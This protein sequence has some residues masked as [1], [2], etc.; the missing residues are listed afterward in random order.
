M[1]FTMSLAALRDL[2]D[3]TRL[4]I[5][6]TDRDLT[7]ADESR[8]GERLAS[9]LNAWTAHRQ[10][11]TAGFDVRHGRFLLVGLDESRVAASGCS[12]DALLRELRGL[13]AELGLRLTDAAPVW[14]RT[15][16]GNVACVPRAG[17][18]DLAATGAVDAETAVFDLTVDTLG[19]VRAGRWE[20]PARDSWHARLLGGTR[21]AAG[22]RRS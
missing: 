9:F 5:F 4:W 8:L 22:G 2:P 15:E 3:S 21:S 19:A 16:D 6:G 1:V 14:Y 7:P 20:L 10:E 12:I 11:L 17:F 18:R 13:E